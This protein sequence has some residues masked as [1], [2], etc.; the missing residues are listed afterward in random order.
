MALDRDAETWLAKIGCHCGV[1]IVDQ[2][3]DQPL[4]WGVGVYAEA[5]GWHARRYP[6]GRGLG[7]QNK[8]VLQSYPATPIL[9]SGALSTR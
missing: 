6:D 5:A 2:T 4:D 1:A 9:P 7:G 3:D 8:K